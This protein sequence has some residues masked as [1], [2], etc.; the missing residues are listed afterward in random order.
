MSCSVQEGFER[1]DQKE[2]AAELWK[3]QLHR[4][5][6]HSFVMKVWTRSSL[7]D[8]RMSTVHTLTRSLAGRALMSVGID[9]QPL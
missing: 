1:I 6:K 5:S 8:I 7:R 4:A 9:G 2:T 3:E